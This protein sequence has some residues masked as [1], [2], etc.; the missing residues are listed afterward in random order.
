MDAAADRQP[1]QS[2]DVSQ[3]HDRALRGFQAFQGVLQLLQALGEA[4]FIGYPLVELD[5]LLSPPYVDLLPSK[6]LYIGESPVTLRSGPVASSADAN[7][8]TKTPQRRQSV[9]NTVRILENFLMF[10]FS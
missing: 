10:F 1:G 7:I 9:S 2:V 6:S 5:Q 8:D 4:F 3:A